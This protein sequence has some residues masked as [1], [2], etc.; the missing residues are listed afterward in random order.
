M[1]KITNAQAEDFIGAPLYVAARVLGASV[2]E[3]V[4]VPTGATYAVFKGTD[5]FYVNYS[6]TAT[7]PI[8]NDTGTANELNPD[9]RIV[10]GLTTL[11]IISA[12]TP[13]ITIAFYD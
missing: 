1:R 4:T 12:G 11:S 5:N 6:G 9:K 3:S 2:A 7:V 10:D 13:I 8:D